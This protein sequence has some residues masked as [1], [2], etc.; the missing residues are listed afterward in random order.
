M[1]QRIATFTERYQAAARKLKEQFGYTNQH[2]VPKITKV[3]LNVGVGR[4]VRDAKELETVVKSLERITGQKPVR[5]SARKSIASFKIRAGMP[6]GAMVTLRGRPMRH[7]LEKL[8]HA[9]LPRV[10]DFQ[11]LSPTS[12]DRH[13]IYTLGLKEHLVF[14]EIASDSVDQIHGV[15]ITIVTTAKTPAEGLTLLRALGFPLQA[16]RR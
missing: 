16:S 13:G 15:G 8:I 9:A 11:G 5:T 2:A 4:A 10:R 7:F 6:I 1:N 3:V 12:F 14:P